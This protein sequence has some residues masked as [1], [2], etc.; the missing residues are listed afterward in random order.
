MLIQK[1]T[2]AATIV[3]SIA[4]SH[5][6][7]TADA[8]NISGKLNMNTAKQITSINSCLVILLHPCLFTLYVKCK[9]IIDIMQTENAKNLQR[10]AV[11]WGEWVGVGLGLWGRGIGHHTVIKYHNAHERP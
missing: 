3:K 1:A 10:I 8:S 6:P 5:H 4:I 11:F 2:N 7:P 9:Y